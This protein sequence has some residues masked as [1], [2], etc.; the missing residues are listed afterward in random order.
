MYELF[1]DYIYVLQTHQKS[2]SYNYTNM[3]VIRTLTHPLIYADEGDLPLGSGFLSK[4]EK[5][6]IKLNETYKVKNIK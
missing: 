2:L 5:E 6:I 4:E 1:R 3:E